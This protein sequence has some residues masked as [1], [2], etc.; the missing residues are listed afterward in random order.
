M[1]DTIAETYL[2]LYENRIKQID[3]DHPSLNHLRTLASADK[4]LGEIIHDRKDQHLVI[5]HD[6]MPVAFAIP[7]Q[8]KDNR[9]RSGPIFT[10]PDYRGR[11][12][13][14]ELLSHIFDN[15]SGRS[16]IEKDNIASKKSF[17]SIGFKP[18]GRIIKYDG[19]ELHEYLKD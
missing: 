12:F 6:G 10:H 11:G 19:E 15:K 5:H 14:K 3:Y 2:K 13:G 16:F 9:W 1:Y 8:D 18:S 4:F 17:E 7:R